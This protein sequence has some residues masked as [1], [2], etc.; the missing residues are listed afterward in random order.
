VAETRILSIIG[1]KSAGK[2]TLAV[3]LASE[4]AR[5]GKRVMAIKHAR[6]PSEVD[7]PGTDSHR[8][9]HEGKAERVLIAGPDLRVV[10]ERR[11]DDTDPIALAR[12]YF[13]GAEIVLVEGFKAAELPK[14]EV[15]RRAASDTP[16]FDPSLPSAGQW[17]AIV[18]DDERFDAPCPVLRFRDTMW[19]QLLANLA[20]DRAKVI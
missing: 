7:R 5:K 17:I 14:I 3:A 19:L 9:F 6:H 2:T 1:R 10:F 12:Q 16:V 20:W 4:F 8:L 11:P 13:E 18:T 15:F